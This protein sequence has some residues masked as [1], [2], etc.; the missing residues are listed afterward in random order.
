MQILHREWT[1]SREMSQAPEEMMAVSSAR[2]EL[3]PVLSLHSSRVF[4][5][6]TYY[7]VPIKRFFTYTYFG[8]PLRCFFAY[9]YGVSI[10]RFIVVSIR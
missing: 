5:T 4:F 10:R 6:Y 8:V 7:G 2:K 1:F 9:T 3:A